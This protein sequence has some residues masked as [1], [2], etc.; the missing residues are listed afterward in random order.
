MTEHFHKI[1]VGGIFDLFKDKVYSDGCVM[2]VLKGGGG[3]TLC[4]FLQNMSDE[5]KELLKRG[6]IRTKIIE[7]DNFIFPL[8]Q[9]NNTDFI[10]EIDFNPFLYKDERKKLSGKSNI[11]NIIGVELTDYTVQAIRMVNMPKKLYSK[12]ITSW[13]TSNPKTFTKG[14]TKWTDRL[15]RNYT[16][17]QLWNMSVYVGK[18]GEK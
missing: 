11:V 13:N 2:E 6:K 18:F 3:F 1:K 14:Y 16:V 15:R 12:Y 17:S 5:E 9:F 8:I 7:E 10:F 4:I